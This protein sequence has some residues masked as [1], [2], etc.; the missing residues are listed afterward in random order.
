MFGRQRALDQAL[1]DCNAA[2]AA[3]AQH[4]PAYRCRGA[5]YHERK[6][7]DRAIAEQNRAPSINPRYAGAYWERGRAF[8]GK[9]DQTRALADYNEAIKI[10][11][12]YAN[13]SLGQR[14]V[15]N[16]GRRRIRCRV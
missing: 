15:R 12:K 16:F 7:Y 8:A 2:I 6:D 14:G 4:A 10:N 5:V 3:D 1:D 11:S 9:D 13:P